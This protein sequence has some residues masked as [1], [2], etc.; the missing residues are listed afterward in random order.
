MVKPRM[1]PTALNWE[2][3]VSTAKKTSPLTIDEFE[4]LDLAPRCEFHEGQVWNAQATTPAHNNLQGALS[5]V[6]RSL[7][8]KKPG[9]SR[10]GG[11][12]ILPEAAVRYGTKSLFV[13]D[14]AGWRRTRVPE[15]PKEFPIRQRPDWVCEILSTNQANDRHTKRLVLHEQEVPFYWRV[16]PNERMIEVY[17]WDDKGYILS[18]SQNEAFVGRIPPFDATD[19][20]ASVLFGEEDA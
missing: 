2:S 5:E 7:F 10:P 11:W 13:Q 15:I 18:Q 9:G 3:T 8:H 4:T 19:L 6:L 17:E 14:L 16:D 1:M 12:W 20:K